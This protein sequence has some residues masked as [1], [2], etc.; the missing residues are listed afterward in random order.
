VRA[1]SLIAHPGLSH[2]E[3][4]TTTVAEG[5]GGRMGP[6]WAWLARHTGMAVED[7]ARPQIRAAT[8]PRA[9]GGEFYG[10]RFVNNGRA[11][12]LPVLRPGADQAITTLWRVCERETGVPLVV[13]R[14]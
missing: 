7:G 14:P 11:V 3:L 6:F 1:Q 5:G 12:R 9:R 13:G 2:S 4:Q 8:D 10:P